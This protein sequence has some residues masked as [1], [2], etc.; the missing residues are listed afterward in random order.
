MDPYFR[1]EVINAM[2]NPNITTYLAMHQDYSEDF[3]YNEIQDMTIDERKA[4]EIIVRRL[5]KVKHFGPL[6]HASIVFNVGYFPHSVLQQARTHRVG[7]CLSGDTEVQFGHSSLKSESEVY[8][9]STIKHLAD[10]WHNGRKHQRTSADAAYMQKQISSRKLLHLNEDTGFVQHTKITNIFIN[11]EKEVYEI[12]FD[13]GD[14]IK[15]TLDHKVYTPKGWSTFKELSVGDYVMMAASKA[16]FKNNDNSCI[17]ELNL[18]Q[19][20]L[21]NEVWVKCKGY[22]WY[23]VSNY[24]RVRSWAPKKHRGKLSYPKKPR[25]KKLCNDA[26]GRY[27]YVSLANGFGKSDR[28]NVHV[29]VMEGFHGDNPKELVRHKNGI[30]YDNRLENLTFGTEAENAKDRVLHNVTSKKK[31]I[32]VKITSITYAGKEETYDIEVEGPYHNFIAN[33]IVV[34]NSF[35]CQSFRYTGHRIISA[36]LGEIPLEQVFYLRPPGFYTDRQGHKYEY[37]EELRTHHLDL[38]AAAAI[39]YQTNIEKHGMSEEHAR[40]LIPFDTRQN[41][42]VSFN[43][44]SLMH[45]FDMRMPLDAQL[46]IQQMCKLMYPHFEQWVPEIAEWYTQTRKG[47]NQ[48][49]P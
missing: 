26:S 17:H 48:L 14:S 5:L 22:P 32:P 41:F 2:P 30:P 7:C 3:V 34:H 1:V 10:L 27:Q 19:E 38:C 18:N 42:I 4:G 16:L 36:A 46:E 35:D 15:A 20:N 39:E 21:E 43:I 45:Y 13:S 9:K 47:K 37:T 44:R 28:K 8:Y 23:E 29:L 49:A 40:S 31:A 6:E 33:N 11:G 12:C 25:L 24:G